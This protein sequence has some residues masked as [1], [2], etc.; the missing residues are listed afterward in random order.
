MHF[1]PPPSE[2]KKKREV[3]DEDEDVWSGEEGSGGYQ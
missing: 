1:I 3:E 2:K